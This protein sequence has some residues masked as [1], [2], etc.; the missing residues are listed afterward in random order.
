MVVKFCLSNS[1]R[2]WLG[3]L[4]NAVLMVL[5]GPKRGE[6]TAVEEHYITEGVTW[7]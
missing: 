4:E 6:V 3:V 7:A 2:T 1:K 5:L